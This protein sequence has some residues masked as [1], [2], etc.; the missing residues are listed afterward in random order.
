MSSSL[1][2]WSKNDFFDQKVILE[3]AIFLLADLR[4]FKKKQFKPSQNIIR[5]HTRLCDDSDWERAPFEV[6]KFSVKDDCSYA[7]FDWDEI[8]DMEVRIEDNLTLTE[9][10]VVAACIY[11]A[12]DDTIATEEGIKRFLGKLDEQTKTIKENR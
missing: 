9:A 6:H 11:S 5:I 2:F 4:Y 3:K 8:L 7:I 10:E 12:Y 1:I